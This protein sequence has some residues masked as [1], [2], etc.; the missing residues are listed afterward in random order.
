MRYWLFK[1]EPSTWSWDQQVA[2]G[3]K[4]EEWDGVRNYQA[5]NFMRE[6]EV[7]D[8]G[9]FYHSQKDKA[10]VG[11]VEVIA[12]AH[13]DSTTDDERWECVDVKAVEA[14]PRPVTLDEIKARE[15]L[16]EMALVKN[17]RL[18]VQPVTEKE[19]KIVREMG[20]L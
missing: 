10:V 11:I 3:D 6:M 12:E 8:L 18:S 14:L 4:G 20:G 13:P 9:F 2:R 15:D 5:R 16:A 7:G 19:W 17:S 1:S